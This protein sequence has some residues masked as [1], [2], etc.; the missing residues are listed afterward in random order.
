VVCLAALVVPRNSPHVTRSVNTVVVGSLGC[1][2]VAM[3]T[4]SLIVPFLASGMMLTEWQRLTLLTPLV[5]EPL[6]ATALVVAIG[7]VAVARG[8]RL[9]L[10]TCA[11]ATAGV[12]AAFAAGENLGHIAAVLADE[13]IPSGSADR[14]A[15]AVRGRAVL[16]AL[17]HLAETWSVGAAIWLATRCAAR[18]R[19]AAV[20]VGV[21]TAIACHAWWNATVLRWWPIPWPLLGLLAV[22][23]GCAVAFCLAAARTQRR[24]AESAPAPVRGVASVP[25]PSRVP[26]PPE[27][28]RRLHR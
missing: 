27:H 5:E 20:L 23:I 4:A 2:L 1:G 28:D 17:G 24:E 25:P 8:E 15:A 19:S 21:L 7:T 12:V 14:I 16:P 26:S 10:R 3:G 13:P 11:I 6:K 22:S 9:S 18:W